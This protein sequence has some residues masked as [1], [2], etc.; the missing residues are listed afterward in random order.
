M[1]DAKPKAAENNCLAAAA[2][3][4]PPRCVCRPIQV[5]EADTCRTTCATLPPMRGSCYLVVHCVLGVVLTSFTADSEAEAEKSLL[6]MRLGHIPHVR[7]MELPFAGSWK[8]SSA[9]SSAQHMSKLF[10]IDLRCASTQIDI[11]LLF[12]G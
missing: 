6:S 12:G 1:C 3:C 11:M 2:L 5:Q 9:P 10:E 7:H 4:T 8:A